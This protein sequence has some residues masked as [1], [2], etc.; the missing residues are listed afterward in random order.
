M[1]LAEI[2]PVE[3]V[4]DLYHPSTGEPI[5]IKLTL[6]SLYDPKFEKIQR[7]ILNKRLALEVRG[8]TFKAED[9]KEN[10]NE[11]LVALVDGWDWQEGVV[12]HGEQPAFTPANVK[13]FFAE[14]PWFKEQLM[15]AV[16]DQKD[17]FR[18]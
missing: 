3:R 12:F 16:N 1:D 8:K 11:L 15:E 7:S 14:N 6:V 9:L 2:K 5:G 10:E 18:G 17:F 13:K 4:I